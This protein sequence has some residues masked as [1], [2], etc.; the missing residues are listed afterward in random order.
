MTSKRS[1]L[2]AALLTTAVSVAGCS[3]IS[4]INPFDKKEANK[5]LATQGQRISVIAF[6]Q[7][8]E[9]A[10]ALKGSDFY[11]P[12]ATVQADWPLPGGNAAQSVEHVAAAA[13]FDIAWTKGFG[14]KGN[15]KYHVTAPPVA[16][17]GKVFVMDG[18]A[19]V[20]AID[21]RSGSTIWRKDLRPAKAPGKKHGFLGIGGSAADRTGFGGGVAYANGKL[22]VSSGFRF[23]AQLDAATG[24]EAWRQET[25]TPIHAAPTVADG[26]VFVTSTDNELLT[27]AA[28][29]GAPGWTYQA[30]IEPARILGASSP[31]VSGDTV[32]A[33][34]ASGELVALRTSN[35]NDLW[36]EALSRASRTNAL[37]EIRD[38]AGRP[39]IFKGD[40]FAVSHSGV[41]SATDLRTGQAR[42]SLPVTAITTPWAAGDVVYVV[43]KGGQV[44][45]VSREAG[46]VYWI[47]DLN[48]TDKLSKRQKKK[49]AKHPLLWSTPIL[50]SGRLITV[51][52]EGE[53]LALNPKT[54]ETVKSIKVGSTLLG[55]IAM[56]D[57]VYVVTDGADLV[58]IR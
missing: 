52:S 42:W 15:R 35:G 25:S 23:V 37:S 6:D 2:L 34:F 46:Q 13:N 47:R 24:V 26:R 57:T 32:V 5:T 18:E 51:S 55:P 17:D 1:L 3:T 40:V 11:L 41:F 22:Y 21:A 44:I 49:R 9:P 38:I 54:G 19:T 8:V 58:A 48:N 33:G 29:D 4:K 31:A 28:T 14:Q 7:K 30:L 53:A 27:F 20:V 16:A 45:C 12:D 10:E 56:G 50:A 43:D 39:V 36:S